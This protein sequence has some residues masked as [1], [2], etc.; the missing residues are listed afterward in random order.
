MS[1]LFKN[2]GGLINVYNRICESG[3]QPVLS[4]M[5]N[6]KNGKPK[7]TLTSNL[8]VYSLFSVFLTSLLQ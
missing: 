7:T 1:R 3:V 4:G 2:D 5:E 6:Q 8:R